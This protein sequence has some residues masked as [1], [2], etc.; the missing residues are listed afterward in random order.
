MIYRVVVRSVCVELQAR[1]TILC[2]AKLENIRN[3][4]LGWTND[5]ESL[6]D[7]ERNSLWIIKAW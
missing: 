5:S 3:N 7:G 6:L 1:F 2:A 4:L